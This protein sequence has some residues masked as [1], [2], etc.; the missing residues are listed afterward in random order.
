MRSPTG[1]LHQWGRTA[2][3]DPLKTRPD[4]YGHPFDESGMFPL[5]G[6]GDVDECRVPDESLVQ[7]PDYYEIPGIEWDHPVQGRK[8]LTVWDIVH[9]LNLNHQQGNII[10]YTIR[11]GRKPGQPRAKDTRKVF[12]CAVSELRRLGEG[13]PNEER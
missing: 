10:K 11:A 12:W 5:V 8:T 2:E 13:P 1:S 9:A 3:A 4:V 7:N 6:I